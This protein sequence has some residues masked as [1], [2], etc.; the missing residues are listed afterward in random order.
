[1]VTIDSAMITEAQP[2]LQIRFN[3]GTCVGRELQVSCTPFIWRGT[4]W[5]N[6]TV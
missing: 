3:V 2:K 5:K 4:S 6:S 1:M